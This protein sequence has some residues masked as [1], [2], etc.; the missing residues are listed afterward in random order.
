M[1]NIIILA[2]GVILLG[3][4]L[5]TLSWWEEPVPMT[6]SRPSSPEKPA[7]EKPAVAPA[8]NS[9]KLAAPAS[10]ASPTL[11]KA[12][13]S[14]P[15]PQQSASAP[16]QSAS[17]QQKSALAPQRSTPAPQPAESPVL[18]A[19]SFDIVRVAKDG[20]A[21]IAGRAPAGSTVELSL[22]GQILA[23][24]PVSKRGEWVAVIDQP[25][26]SGQTELD[27]VAIMPNGRRIASANIVALVVP[28][29]T[30]PAETTK[31]ASAMA[32]PAK[33]TPP[34]VAPAKTV[35][36]KAAP[37]KPAVVE[38]KTTTALAI[39]LPKSGDAPAKLLQ[40]P[41]P[42]D[43]ASSSKLSVDT[44]DYDDKGNVVV[45]GSAPKGAKVQV[46]VD[47]KP[48][49]IAK[50]DQAKSWQLKPKSE[51]APGGHT[52]RVDQVEGSGKVVSRIELPFVRAAA[53]DV[54]ANTKARY[55]V[56]VQPGNSLWRIARRVYGSGNRFTVIY[57]A[58]N[59]QIRDPDMI[60]PGQ[61]FN[62]PTEN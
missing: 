4:L 6:A 35:S 29:Q 24:A 51:V 38:K 11:P 44:V 5:A 42:K 15:A 50:A 8:D 25:M 7:I 18:K 59:D 14:T 52:L 62:L 48:V 56:I 22:G 20:T 21:V 40:K 39:L 3:G 47:N 16:Q 53:A 60:F 58:N 41:E 37:A 33:T 55:R 1:R 13:K 32:A 10:A 46:Y 49:G 57:Q 30:P 36:P 12:G 17:A 43:G 31:T 61:V 26:P 54:L 19:P 28:A 9:N 45:T 2:A 23:E 34:K 27:L